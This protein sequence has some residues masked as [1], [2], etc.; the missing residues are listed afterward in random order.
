MTGCEYE[1]GHE[2]LVPIAFAWLLLLCWAE[3]VVPR[4]RK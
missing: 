2:A 4:G 1:P 3:L